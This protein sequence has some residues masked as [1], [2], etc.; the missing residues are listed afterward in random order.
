MEEIR[1]SAVTDLLKLSFFNVG[2]GDSILI[3]ESSDHSRFRMLIDTGRPDVTPAPD[4]LRQ[5]CAEHLRALGIDRI[6]TLVITHLHMDHF[7]GLRELIPEVAFGDLYTSYVP[8]KPGSLIPEEPDAVKT[9]RGMID[10]VNRFSAD[11]AALESRGCRLHAVD[12]IVH[13]QFSEMLS[14]DIIPISELQSLQKTVWDGMIEGKPFTEDEKYRASKSRNPGSLRIRLHYGAQNIELAGDC[15]GVVW[16]SN[17]TPCKIF[18]V[19]HHGDA[20]SLTDTLV[21]NLRPE[22]AVISCAMEYNPKKDRP[23]AQAIDLLRDCG[24]TVLFTDAYDDGHAAPKHHRAV[25]FILPG[26]DTVRVS[27]Y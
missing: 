20:K 17:A 11:T 4:S 12:R 5:T 18:K 6:D 19:P 22:Y 14:A 13:L 10:C 7:G 9:V 16:E 2:N 15:Y 24:T 27:N 23:S 26:D 1:E 8:D 21:R 3:E 25:E